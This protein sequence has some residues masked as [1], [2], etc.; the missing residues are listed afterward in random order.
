MKRNPKR[1]AVIVTVVRDCPECPHVQDD[2]DGYY[3]C[4]W[5]GATYG[6]G[7]QPYD[8]PPDWCPLQKVEET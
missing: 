6:R 7:I 1:L 8:G 2:G 4:M 3:R 5:G